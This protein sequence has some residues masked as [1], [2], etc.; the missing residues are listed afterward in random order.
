MAHS[1]YGA[2][3]SDI[4]H[5]AEVSRLVGSAPGNPAPWTDFDAQEIEAIFA[6]LE[7]RSRE[8]LADS[9]IAEKDVTLSRSVDVRYRR[10]THELIIPVAAP[11]VDPAAVQ[12]LVEDFEATYEDTYGHGAGFREAG[13]EFTTFRL[14]AVG[15]TPKPAFAAHEVKPLTPS[16]ARPVYDVASGEWLETPVLHWESLASNAHVAGPAIVEHP[17]T[18]VYVAAGQQVSVDWVGNLLIT[19]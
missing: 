8:L 12:R 11:V 18:T 17:M 16:P 4:H 14:D 13:V 9:G 10:Q 1:A 15:Q 5:G 6:G 19:L 7:A 2:L 3:A